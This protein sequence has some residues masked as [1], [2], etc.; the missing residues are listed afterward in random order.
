MSA[1]SLRRVAWSASLVALPVV[2]GAQDSVVPNRGI[3]PLSR[4]NEST[5]YSIELLFDSAK[6]AGLPTWPLESKALEGITKRADGRRIVAAVRLV[7]R[8]LR[9]ARSALGPGATNDE[10]TAAAGALSVG[11]TTDELARLVKSRH[12]KQLT[13]PLVVLSDLITRG[14]PRDTASQTIFQLWQRGASDDD[15]QGL[16]RG[17]ERDIVSGTDPGVALLNRAREIPSRGPP[18]APPASG[19]RPE[20]SENPNP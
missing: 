10:L 1:L 8:S 12:E 11:I 2:V 7:F 9:E 18:T 4:L 15:F 3:D 6:V 19:A 13:Y 16:W 5:R 20:R 14:V 17:V